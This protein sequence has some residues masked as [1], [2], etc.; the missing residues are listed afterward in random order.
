MSDPKK[1]TQEQFEQAM[2]LVLDLCAEILRRWKVEY[3]ADIDRRLTE[4]GYVTQDEVASLGRFV[5][6][7]MKEFWEKQPRP[8][9]TRRPAPTMIMWH[10]TQDEKPP[11][12][13]PVVLVDP[14]GLV[15]FGW[16]VGGRWWRVGD[17]RRVIPPEQCCT[18]SQ[19][20]TFR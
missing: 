7:R 4:L 19:W 8:E 20:G 6:E 2:P 9:P 15:S 5:N 10:R 1:Y 16:F 12:S 13:E 17:D 14:D 3:R 18:P 11:V